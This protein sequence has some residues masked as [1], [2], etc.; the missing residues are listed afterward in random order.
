[1]PNS[2]SPLLQIILGPDWGSGT[3]PRSPA[4]EELGRWGQSDIH[5]DLVSPRERNYDT[6]ANY[7]QPRLW[8]EDLIQTQPEGWL[9]KDAIPLWA[10]LPSMAR[11]E[12]RRFPD[13]QIHYDTPFTWG[14][15]TTG[16]PRS[17]FSTTVFTLP[18]PTRRRR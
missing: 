11:R 8:P 5:R 1:M 15:P 4:E 13:T 7:P 3:L 9:A 6:T 17:G 14:V 16:S 12:R 18:R 10:M 2:L